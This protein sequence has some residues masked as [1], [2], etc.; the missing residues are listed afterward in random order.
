MYLVVDAIESCERG[1]GAASG[2]HLCAAAA[3]IGQ[4]AVISGVLQLMSAANL[5][6]LGSEKEE[7]E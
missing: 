3:E 6:F 4:I 5:T 7:L 1:A 2:H